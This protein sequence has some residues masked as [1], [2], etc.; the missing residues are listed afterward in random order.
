VSLI[1]A[2]PQ[3]RSWLD[4]TH[5]RAGGGVPVLYHPCNTAHHRILPKTG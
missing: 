4:V 2:F 5:G 3:V 1:S